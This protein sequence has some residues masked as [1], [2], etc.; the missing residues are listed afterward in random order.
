[1]IKKVIILSLIILFVLNNLYTKSNFDNYALQNLT[2][3]SVIRPT[4]TLF[5]D[6]YDEYSRYFYDDKKSVSLIKIKD[7]NLEIK[8]IKEHNS[9]IYELYQ[10][11]LGNLKLLEYDEN[12]KL[13][14]NVKYF[15]NLLNQDTSN[16]QNL[17]QDYEKNM[18]DIT[19]MLDINTTDYSN[20][21][22]S[23]TK[24]EFTYEDNLNKII[25]PESINDF[26]KNDVVDEF[27]FKKQSILENDIKESEAGPWNQIKM[28]YECSSHPFL[29]QK[30]LIL[31][32]VYCKDGEMSNCV[33]QSTTVYDVLPPSDLAVN[34][35]INKQ[36]PRDESLVDKL[37]LIIF[38][39]QKYDIKKGELVSNVISYN[40]IYNLNNKYISFGTDNILKFIEDM[41]MENLLFENGFDVN[42]Y[43]TNHKEEIK[44]MVS[45][46]ELDNHEFNIDVNFEREL[47]LHNSIF[48]LNF[49]SLKK[50]Q[51]CSQFITME[52]F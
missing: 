35:Y 38:T 44:D 9:Y 34:E 12:N 1:M 20:F 37:P 50:C 48:N 31:E 51:F 30:M 8:K 43:N 45:E 7:I 16:S 47:F 46:V 36:Y 17:I 39:Y 15:E 40:G 25:L 22:S 19:N 14:F 41:F 11:Y 26:F 4:L 3:V 29:N 23:V 21:I 5:Y 33:N 18:K 27:I 52:R 2:S 49:K 24:I 28:I 13:T 32:E 6:K 10:E 42:S